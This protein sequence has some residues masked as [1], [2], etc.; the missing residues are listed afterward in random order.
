M[1]SIKSWW[2]LSFTSGSTGH[3]AVTPLP[4]TPKLAETDFPL[5][6]WGAISG[7]SFRSLGMLP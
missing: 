4:S 3:R 7:G 5:Q 6:G 2:P 1:G